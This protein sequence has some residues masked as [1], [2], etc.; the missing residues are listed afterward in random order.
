MIQWLVHRVTAF[1]RGLEATLIISIRQ[2]AFCSK[3]AKS[4]P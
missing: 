4:V 2:R 1:E 3:S